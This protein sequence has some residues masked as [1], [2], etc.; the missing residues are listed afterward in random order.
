MNWRP[1]EEAG[2]GHG[3]VLGAWEPTAAHAGDRRW[4]GEVLGVGSAA[5]ARLQE[6]HGCGGGQGNAV[7]LAASDAAAAACVPAVCSTTATVLRA[8]CRHDV[9]AGSELR[10]RPGLGGPVRVRQSAYDR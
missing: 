10:Q 8:L 4:C 6:A 1:N 9:R 2:L 5:V 7:V 3:M